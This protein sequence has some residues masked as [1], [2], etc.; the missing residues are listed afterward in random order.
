MSKNSQKNKESNDQ[1]NH[2]AIAF[3]G[4]K[5]FKM[6]KHG[7]SSSVYI[8]HWRFTPLG[9]K[10]CKSS[11]EQFPKGSID[12][13]QSTPHTQWGAVLI[14]N[15]YNSVYFMPLQLEQFFTLAASNMLYLIVPICWNAFVFT[16]PLVAI[17]FL[18]LPVNIIVYISVENWFDH[19]FKSRQ[20]NPK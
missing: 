3:I 6:L 17:G 18:F 16:I 4:K 15:R 7:L 9:A 8:H 19:S 12:L 1:R 13:K 5:F 11:M 20:T 10:R 14:L 2:G